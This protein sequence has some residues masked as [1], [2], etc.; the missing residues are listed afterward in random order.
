MIPAYWL[1]VAQ[2]GGNAMIE[3]L[4]YLAIFVIVAIVVWW[5]LQQLALPEPLGRILMIAMV[6]IGAIIIIVLLL[7]FTGVASLP[8]HL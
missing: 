4:V 1:I 8:M 2:P 5:L 3:L 7:R 6:L